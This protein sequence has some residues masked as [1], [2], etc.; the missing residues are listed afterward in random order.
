[1]GARTSQSFVERAPYASHE[2][3]PS[4]TAVLVRS[5]KPSNAMIQRMAEWQ[6]SL[7]EAHIRMHISLDTTHGTDAAETVK[8]SV[9]EA[10]IHTYDERE[11]LT[12]FPHLNEVITKMPGAGE[13]SGLRQLADGMTAERVDAALEGGW[14]KWAG[15]KSSLAWGMHTEAIVLCWRSLVQAKSVDQKQMPQFV[16]VLEDDVGFTAELAELVQAYEGDAEAD[17]ITDEPTRSEPLRK[18][19]CEPKPDG[20]PGSNVRWEGWCWHDT[21]T[22]D[23][24]SLVPSDRRWKTK[25]HAQRF[26]SRLIEELATRC[27]A[28]CSAWS[29][30]LAC[31]LCLAMPKLTC[32]GL[33]RSTLPPHPKRQY[34][35]DGKVSESEYRDLCSNP[36]TRGVLLHAMKW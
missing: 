34:N 12:A 9:P 1:M 22:D 31:S 28:G 36:H 11:M 6:R 4:P 10:S 3:M 20:Q 27:E 33:R 21:C 25:E 18:V 26:S 19:R 30:Q 15:E 7:A 17:L 16:W 24:A 5:H 13:W 35:H 32:V 8:A 14:R 29:E 2:R 23:Y